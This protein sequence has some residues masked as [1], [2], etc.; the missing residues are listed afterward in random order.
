MRGS[1][2]WFL[3]EGAPSFPPPA[4]AEEEEEQ[5]EEE[6]EEE[7]KQEREREYEMKRWSANYEQREVETTMFII[8]S[9]IS[10]TGRLCKYAFWKQHWLIFLFC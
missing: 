8:A 5:K 4:S 6:E 10:G 1:A 7:E 3:L 2:W 9:K